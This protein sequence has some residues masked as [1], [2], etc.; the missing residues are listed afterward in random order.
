MRA[1]SAIGQGGVVTAGEFPSIGRPEWLRGQI[2]RL[3]DAGV[4][5]TDYLG[6][7]A[8]RRVPAGSNA[9]L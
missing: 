4:P 7:F 8:V 3:V 9:R 6:R 1:G 2:I 5:R